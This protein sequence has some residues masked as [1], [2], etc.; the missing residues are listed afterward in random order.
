MTQNITWWRCRFWCRDAGGRTLSFKAKFHLPASPLTD[1][2]KAVLLELLSQLPEVQSRLTVI[3]SGITLL[4]K[5][6]QIIV[7][8]TLAGEALRASYREHLYVASLKETSPP[9]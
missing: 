5:C 9:P 3:S 8:E 4:T 7:D 1:E 2:Q 6:G